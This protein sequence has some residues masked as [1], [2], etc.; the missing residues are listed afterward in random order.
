M[1]NP[2]PKGWNRDRLDA[3]A[4]LERTTVLP[5]DIQAGTKYIG[6]EHIDSSGAFL[7]VAEVDA[8]ELASNKFAF[9]RH[10]VLYGKLRPYLMKIARPDFSGV[11]STEILPIRANGKVIRDYLYY[12]L[13]QPRMVALAN[14]RTAGANLPRLSP[15]DLAAFPIDYPGSTEEQRRIAD[16]LDR[17]DAL[18][19]KQTDAIRLVNELAPSVFY[20]MFGDPRTNPKHWSRKPLSQVVDQNR[21]ITY[22]ILKPG[23]YVEDGIPMLRIQDI[24]GYRVATSSLHRV[25]PELSKQYKRT[26]LR[27]DEIVIS[28]VGTVGLVACVPDTLCGANVHRNLGVIVPGRAIRRDYL[29]WMLR[30]NP[31]LIRSAMKGGVQSLLNLGDLEAL[32]IPVP[33]CQL[34]DE[35]VVKSTQITEVGT[36]IANAAAETNTLFS[37]L[38]QQA[39]RGKL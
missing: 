12:F 35:F 11:C 20:E 29:F 15:S 33:P 38:L 3:V 10:H 4:E 23:D 18:R 5:Q 36:R 30:A 37:S 26:I 19:R 16:I 9:S 24:Q 22:G 39:F 31:S 6:L 1:T 14:A 27:G 28:L 8:G 25:S 34:Q 21:P 17:A 32:T 13:R 7:D 2:L